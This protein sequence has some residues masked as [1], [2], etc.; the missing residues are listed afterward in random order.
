MRVRASFSAGHLTTPKS[1][2]VRAGPLSPDVASALAGLLRR[3]HWTADDDLV[4]VGTVGSSEPG[5]I[6]R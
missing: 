5:N 2:N 1:G 6:G 3:E 4:F